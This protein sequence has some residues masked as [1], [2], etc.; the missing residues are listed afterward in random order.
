MDYHRSVAVADQDA[1]L[2][3]IHGFL[4]DEDGPNWTEDASYTLA[5]EGK[6]F[7]ETAGA[8]KSYL[9]FRKGGDFVEIGEVGSNG[10]SN[11]YGDGSGASAAELNICS[12]LSIE[13]VSL[14]SGLYLP[15]SNTGTLHLYADEDRV[16]LVLEAHQANVSSLVYAGRYSPHCAAQDDSSPVVV[17][18]NSAGILRRAAGLPTD[19]QFPD[20]V[21]KRDPL[22]RKRNLVRWGAGF[23]QGEFHVIPDADL[24]LPWNDR[25]A[26]ATVFNYPMFVLF[27]ESNKGESISLAG[28][29]ADGI[30]RTSDGLRV[31]DTLTIGLNVYRIFGLDAFGESPRRLLIGPVG[32]ELEA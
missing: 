28:A 2:V 22:N 1:V 3:A 17:L 11:G 15:P 29:G 18:S 10:E 26:S 32:E 4:T 31:G 25:A 7:I 24:P 12:A 21:T 9:L 6:L 20:I 19:G 23:R 14:R 27:P 13:G 16:I 30:V 8:S 5:V